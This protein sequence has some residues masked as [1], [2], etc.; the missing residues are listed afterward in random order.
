MDHLTA[1]KCAELWFLWHSHFVQ[2]TVG[3]WSECS[4]S[5]LFVYVDLQLIGSCS[6]KW[7]RGI[8]PISFS[9]HCCWW[10]KSSGMCCHVFEIMFTCVSKDCNGFI[11]GLKNYKKRNFPLYCFDSSEFCTLWHQGHSIPGTLSLMS[12][13]FSPQRITVCLQS[14][15]VWTHIKCYCID[16]CKPLFCVQHYSL[17]LNGSKDGGSVELCVM[18]VASLRKIPQM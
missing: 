7:E 1:G 13:L 5:S 11:F 10:F 18:D 2:A 16:I 6:R 8:F 15:S 9:Q 17:F 14:T 12:S 4:V 3:R